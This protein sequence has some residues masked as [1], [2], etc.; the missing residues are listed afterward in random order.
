[1]IC[2][3]SGDTGEQPGRVV[4]AHIIAEGIV[5]G[6]VSAQWSDAA[7]R[8]LGGKVGK[9]LGRRGRLTSAVADVF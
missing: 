7:E 9:P 4:R 3:D 8:M 2:A 5:V 1:M 6:R